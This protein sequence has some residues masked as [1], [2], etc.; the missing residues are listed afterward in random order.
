MSSEI[1][2]KMSLDSSG[3]TTALN[4]VKSGISNMAKTGIEQLNKLVKLISVGLVAGFTA[5]GRSALTYAKE[6]KNLAD[7]AGVNFEEFQKL[8]AA[9]KMVGTESDK[10]ADI[11]KDTA[12]KMGEFISTGSGPFKDFFEQIAPLVGATKEEF[13]GLN[14]DQVLKKYVGYLEQAN[15]NQEQMTFYLEAIGNDATA[16]AP[17]LVN[18]AQKFN[19]WGQAAVLNGQ[20]M[21]D[22]TAKNLKKAQDA[23]DQFKLKAVIKVGELLGGAGN[24]AGLKQLGAEFMALM[25]KV[26]G[27]LADAF[28]NA[29]KVLAAGMMA[30]VDAFGP[31]MLNWMQQIGVSLQIALSDVL[32]VLASALNIDVR[33]DTEKLLLQ[34]AELDGAV[35]QTFGQSF[36]NA[37]SKMDGITVSTE[38]A[39]KFWKQIAAEQGKILNTTEQVEEFIRKQTG[40]LPQINELEKMRKDL[41]DAQLK[42]EEVKESKNYDLI[43]LLE[44]QI[45]DYERILGLVSKYGI[46]LD[47]AKSIIKSQNDDIKD[48]QYLW[49]AIERAKAAGDQRAVTYW[50]N[51]LNLERQALDIMKQT[52]GTYQD[53][54]DIAYAQY[55]LRTGDLDLNG[56]ITLEEQKQKELQ[57]KILEKAHDK[58]ALMEKEKSI[59][60][61]DLI[62]NWADVKKKS[63]ETLQAMQSKDMILQQIH[64]NL[65][66]TRN[67]QATVTTEVENTNY[68]LEK[69]AENQGAVA[70]ATDGVSDSEVIVAQKI[71]I[72]NEKRREAIGLATALKELGGNQTIDVKISTEIAA[73]ISEYLVPHLETHTS[74][75]ES[76]DNSLKCEG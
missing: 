61:R 5:A 26:S 50:Q 11:Y 76:I 41:L 2:M 70:V 69:S 43:S 75:L 12:D 24:F 44:S 33:V 13:I 25:A 74:L 68:K 62:P 22:A 29:V 36:D 6:M 31:K 17:L 18:G 56:E 19:D 49:Q 34:L 38:A 65:D 27:W 15:V 40:T 67:K 35:T 60:V 51:I 54:Y 21:S 47:K 73:N 66:T 28:V 53:A 58:K 72:S 57:D 14:G 45:S 16:L 52:G 39:V 42:L 71:D 23:I 59:L 20:V 37:L 55:V 9:A 63:E 4:K 1:K 64:G 7:I 48:Q 32:N 3:V 8:A 10:L 30:A 46:T